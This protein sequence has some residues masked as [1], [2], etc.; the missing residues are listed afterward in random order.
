M[1][2]LVTIW[3][4]DSTA[5]LQTRVVQIVGATREGDSGYDS[6]SVAGCSV[7]QTKE[8]LSDAFN[9][10]VNMTMTNPTLHIVAVVPMY[11][12]TASEQIQTLYE[13]C[14]SLRHNITLHII[15]LAPEIAPILDSGANLQAASSEYAKSH[16]TLQ[17]LCGNSTLGLSYSIID[18]YAENGAPIGFTVESLSRYIA[19]LQTALLQD[20]YKI[21]SP[22][23]LM[24]HTGD[25]ISM[26]IASL[27]FNRA[28][29]A[30]QLLGLAFLE[31]L[32]NVGI[33]NQRV[34]AQKAAHEAESI[35]AGIS[36]RYPKLFDRAIKP[37]YHD[38]GLDEGQAVAEAAKILDDD[39]KKLKEEILSILRD[40]QLSLPEKEAVLGLVLG[41]DNE[42]I[43]GMQYE[44][45]GLLLDDACEKPINLYIDAFN[46]CC[47]DSGFLPIRG[48]F[49][50]LK[51]YRWNEA[52]EE[53]V[54]CPENHRA[55][56]PLNEIKRLKQEIINSTSFIRDKQDELEHLQKSVKQRN[57]VETIKKQWRRPKGALKD[58]E[59]KEQPLDQQYTPTPGLK[60]KQTVDL[61]KF[62]NP[63]K[64]QLEVGS[65]TSFAAVAMYEAMMNQANIEG[66]TDMSPAYLFYY[67]NIITGRPEGGSNFHEQFEVLGTHGVCY[68]QLYAY[69]INSLSAQP[70]EAAE[71]DAKN[72][73]VLSAKQ[74]PLFNSSDKS[75]TLKRNHTQ[76]TSALSEGYPIGI[77]LKLFED[78]GKKGA[79]ILH[80][81]DTPNAKEEGR[82]AM[83]I[84]G[85]SEENDF[86]IVRN[87]WGEGFGENGYCYIPTAYIDDPDYMD[88]ACIITEISDNVEGA[89]ADVP[90]VLANFAATESEISLAAIRNAIARVRVDLRSSQ[91]LY[92]EYYKYYQRLVMQLTMPKVQ[93]GIRSAAETAQ[94]INFVNV[95]AKKNELEDTFVAKLKDYKNSLIKII[96]FIA[97]ITLGLGISWYFSQT[98][99]FLVLFLISAAICLITIFGYKW[100]KRIKRR[101]L[102]DEL[103]QVAIDARHQAQELLEMQI[104]FHVAGMW[105]NRFHNLSIEIGNTYDRLVSYND[106]LREWQNSYSRQIGTVAATDG[107]MFRLLDATPLLKK[108]FDDNKSDIVNQIDLIDLFGNYQA[109]PDSLDASHKSVED[110]VANVIEGLLSDFNIAN[111]LLGDEFPYL[112]P[113][114][115]QEEISM[116]TNVSQPPY[117]NR[118]MNATP[119]IH[120]VIADINHQRVSQ[121][122]N[123]LNPLFQLKPIQVANDDPTTLILLTIHPHVIA[124]N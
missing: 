37:L 2:S 24:A 117:R 96:I 61:R 3:T 43:R 91:K 120:I 122:A 85:Y 111:F 116:L 121:W 48:D 115:I 10:L 62:F 74:I 44:H 9:R 57:D 80:P 42:N 113:V 100:W 67:S 101:E 56:N 124:L 46:R 18:N 65:C 13:A 5:N 22:A 40:E 7:D 78:F 68:E 39:I 88:F 63:V 83:V 12:K 34:D 93:K 64:N 6:I 35:L 82:H 8:R 106:A 84:V 47:P 4:S 110:S 109:N 70:S 28:A 31:A 99:V 71:E 29:V 114:N 38:N 20:Y 30:R 119:P 123:K 72:H 32:D 104:R 33:N 66:D 108:F 55:L 11:E 41:R 95:D 27:E 79:F 94:S 90:T 16:S 52:T 118:E 81:D 49:E 59:Y 105:I 112:R 92:A 26:G 19:L 75:D 107:Q 73:R 77:S 51:L 102:Q 69:D 60:I 98:Y 89:K 1:S 25:N 14:S 23:L 21:L 15:G 97:V 36:E 53:F 86:Y 17:S 76:L 50:A 58:I 103:D 45:E 54:E 87:S